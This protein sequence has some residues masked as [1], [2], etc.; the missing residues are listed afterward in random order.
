MFHPI[1]LIYLSASSSLEF[2]QDLADKKQHT[3]LHTKYQVLKDSK[4]IPSFIIRYEFL[5]PLYLL[6]LHLLY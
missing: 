6:T 5:Y 3:Q 2:S 4:Y 1:E